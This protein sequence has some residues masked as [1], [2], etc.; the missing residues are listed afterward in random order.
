MSQWR[1]QNIY[2]YT[3][4]LESNEN[5]KKMSCRKNNFKREVYSNTSLPQEIRS[6]KPNLTPKE[7]RKGTMPKS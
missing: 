7:I 6:L 4:Y 2:I 1:N 5:E 3:H